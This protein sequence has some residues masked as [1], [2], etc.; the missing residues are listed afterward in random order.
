[1]KND[2]FS[3]KIVKDKLYLAD[4]WYHLIIRMLRSTFQN[5]G[6]KTVIEVGCGLGGFLLNISK[7]CGEVV[8]LDVSLKA[9]RIAKDLAKQLCLQERVNF[10]VGDAQ[11]LPFREDSGDVLVCSET[12]EHV[13]DYNKAF[14]ELIRV[15][16]KSGYLCLTVPNFLSTAFFENV[17]L[18]LMGQPSYVKSLV[19][20]EKE[21]LFHVFK[22]RRLLN[23][24]DVE[25][26][27]MRSVDFIH[28]P[29][30]VRKFLKIDK[31]LR[32]MSD[33]FENFCTKHFPFLRLAGA[34]IG[35]LVRKKCLVC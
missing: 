18:L 4:P 16:K 32:V 17:I 19:S 6:E 21:H 14:G 31:V 27:T 2:D 25:V 15:T 30:R 34:N 1:M 23:Q 10:V 5:L 12:L 7:S 11:F 3:S 8:G 29:P 20:V 35:V 28:L 26:I 9:I 24:H 22:L 13:P 33:R